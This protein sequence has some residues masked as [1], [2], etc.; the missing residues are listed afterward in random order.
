[1]SST[2][3]EPPTRRPRPV[4]RPAP[5]PDSR[6]CWN[7]AWQRRQTGLLSWQISVVRE[8]ENWVRQS[9]PQCLAK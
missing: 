8:M 4:E 7:S 3:R 2:R 9:L 1:M 6:G 5:Q